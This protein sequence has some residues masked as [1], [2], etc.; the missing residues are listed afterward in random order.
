MQLPAL[1]S[2][3][4]QGGQLP[5][6]ATSEQYAPLIGCL[7][8]LGAWRRD[9]KAE[10]LLKDAEGQWVLCDFG[11]VTST[12]RAYETSNEIMMGEETI[13]RYTTPALQGARGGH[14]APPCEL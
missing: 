12:F 7:A 1:S 2:P 3:R 11:S 13:R 10:N 4:L 9:L 6:L 5:Q 8:D 14:A